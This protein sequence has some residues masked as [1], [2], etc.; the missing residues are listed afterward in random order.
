MRNTK[1][2]MYFAYV[3]N[4]CEFYSFSICFCP[5]LIKKKPL[6]IVA[7]KQFKGTYKYT[8]IGIYHT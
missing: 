7:I 3:K 1:E 4:V 6:E 5:P 2:A 8:D